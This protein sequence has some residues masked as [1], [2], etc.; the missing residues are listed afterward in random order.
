MTPTNCLFI[1]I[2][3]KNI[4]LQKWPYGTLA[5]FHPSSIIEPPSTNIF[6]S[7]LRA[8]LIAIFLHKIFSFF[9]RRVPLFVAQA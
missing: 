8:S 5:S 7:S 2:A 3:L 9:A 6:S 1:E 4:Y